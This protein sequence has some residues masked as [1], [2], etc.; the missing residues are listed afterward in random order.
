ME[1]RTERVEGRQVDDGLTE[2]L[3]GI[4]SAVEAAEAGQVAGARCHPAGRAATWPATWFGLGQA[5][6][7]YEDADEQ[8]RAV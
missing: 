7:R 2:A 6:A 4:K 5:L 3:E 1:P 8:Q